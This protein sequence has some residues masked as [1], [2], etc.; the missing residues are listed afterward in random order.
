M[1]SPDNGSSDQDTNN[2]NPEPHRPVRVRKPTR[3]KA[4]Q[5][6][7]EAAATAAVVKSPKGKK[8]RKA[9]LM[10]TSQLLDEFTME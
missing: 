2:S 5:L 3:D 1:P 8:F 10:N 6:S 7:Q 4:S 9:K